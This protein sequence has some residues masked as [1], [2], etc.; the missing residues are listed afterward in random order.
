MPGTEI[1]VLL[2]KPADIFRD[3]KWIE[4]VDSS[5]EYAGTFDVFFALDTAKERL[6]GAE[7][8]F[9]SAGKT[10]N[11][12]HHISNGAGCADVNVVIPHASSTSEVLYELME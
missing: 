6:G 9:E 2:E 3:L 4:C 11:I 5:F 1:R 7:K 8:F 10:I 12:D